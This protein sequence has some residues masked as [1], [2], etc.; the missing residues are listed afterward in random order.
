M[1]SSHKELPW[2]L[3]TISRPWK[4]VPMKTVNSKDLT[5]T[6]TRTRVMRNTMGA[7]QNYVFNAASEENSVNLSCTAAA[8]K[9][10]I[11][12]TARKLLGSVRN[13]W[14]H[15]F[16][17]TLKWSLLLWVCKIVFYGSFGH[18]LSAQKNLSV[19]LDVDTEKHY[20]SLNY[21]D[22]IEIRSCSSVT[23][24][25]IFMHILSSA[26]NSF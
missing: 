17:I 23:I 3:W 16:I 15:F 21:P 1:T 9:P 13:Y 14:I 25:I 22:H 20:Y 7:F 4:F 2:L 6:P 24:S 5:F 11:A 18:H 19:C 12:C 10:I 26:N 8:E